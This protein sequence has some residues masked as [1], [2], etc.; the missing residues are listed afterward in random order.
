VPRLGLI[1]GASGRLVPAREV[2]FPLPAFG[3]VYTGIRMPWAGLLEPQATA[4]TGTLKPGGG[5]FLLADSNP[6]GGFRPEDTLRKNNKHPVFSWL[7]T[8]LGLQ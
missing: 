2:S 1:R 7:C 5:R 3:V 6:S 8:D 4:A